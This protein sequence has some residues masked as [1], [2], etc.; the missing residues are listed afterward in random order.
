MKLE[1]FLLVL[2]FLLAP[3]SPAIQVEEDTK[4]DSADPDLGKH[5]KFIG[6]ITKRRAG[7]F[8]STPLTTPTERS[9]LDSSL[10]HQGEHALDNA[11]SQ[12]EG[13]DAQDG[14]KPRK[15]WFWRR[16]RRA[17]GGARRVWNRF[18]NFFRPRRHQ[19]R[20]QQYFAPQRRR[21]SPTHWVRRFFPKLYH[22]NSYQQPRS[23]PG[24]PVFAQPQR[25]RQA[26][27]QIRRSRRSQTRRGPRPIR[28]WHRPRQQAWRPRGPTQTLRRSRPAAPPAFIKMDRIELPTPVPGLQT[29]PLTINPPFHTLRHDMVRFRN[30]VRH[31]QLVHSDQGIVDRL[32]R[33]LHVNLARFA[34]ES[35]R[36]RRYNGLVLRRNQ[37]NRLRNDRNQLRR[38]SL[39]M[40]DRIYRENARLYRRLNSQARLFENSTLTNT[41][42]FYDTSKERTSNFVKPDS[43]DIFY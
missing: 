39:R 15:L 37:Q 30:Q 6:R 32:W 17:S 33:H 41:T 35:R 20:P 4:E 28:T 7:T 21:V 19:A 2:L 34:N 9:L 13:L 8:E 24:R 43:K 31:I 29:A 27:R 25:R 23:R 1:I 42:V 10:S 36:A 16:R 38:S 40:E 12:L 11:D 3:L 22:M 18:R 5:V 14:K 26:R